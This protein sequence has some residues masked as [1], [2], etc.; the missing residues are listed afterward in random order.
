MAAVAELADV[1]VGT[2]YRRFKSKLDLLEAIKHELTDRIV[3]AVEDGV[4]SF[5]K[6][7][8]TGLI[9]DFV[10]TVAGVYSKDEDLYRAVFDI[11]ALQPGVDRIGWEGRQRI[12]EIYQDAISPLLV[13]VPEDR[14]SLAIAVSYSIL[15]NGLVGRAR[16]SDEM[17]TSMKWTDVCHEFGAAAAT[18]LTSAAIL[19]SSRRQS[20]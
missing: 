12:F 2:L 20:S 9:S 3:E 13:D 16:G 1:P 19:S 15:C 17:L 8:L 5:R 18:Y 10:D 14:K 4:V 7:E 11:Q 6:T